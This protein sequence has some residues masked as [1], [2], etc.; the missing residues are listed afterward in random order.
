MNLD[1]FLTSTPD[2]FD[3]QANLSYAE[4]SEIVLFYP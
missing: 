4:L 2:Y 1:W 3:N